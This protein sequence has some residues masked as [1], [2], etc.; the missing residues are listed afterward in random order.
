VKR[1]PNR[2]ILLAAMAL[3]VAAGGM[4]SRPAVGTVDNANGEKVMLMLKK[5]TGRNGG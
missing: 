4:V 3:L 2:R 5:L 1:P